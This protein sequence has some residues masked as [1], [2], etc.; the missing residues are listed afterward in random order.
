MNVD[1]EAEWLEEGEECASVASQ[2]LG[3]S[4]TILS[5]P[6]SAAL[7]A[8]GGSHQPQACHF[9]DESLCVQPSSLTTPS[10]FPLPTTNTLACHISEGFGKYYPELKPSTK[11]LPYTET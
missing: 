10:A 4:R 3:S 9:L 8:P 1:V 11:H 2:L 7:K 6:Y 5:F